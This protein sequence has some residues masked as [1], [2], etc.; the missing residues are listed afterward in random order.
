MSDDSTCTA[1]G[2]RR[3][4]DGSFTLCSKNGCCPTIAFHDDGSATI[5][6]DDQRIEFSRDQLQMLGQSIM[7]NTWAASGAAVAK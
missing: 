6:D 1:P 7:M 5:T 4:Q 3:N 2:I